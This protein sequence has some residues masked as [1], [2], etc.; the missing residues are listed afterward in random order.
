MSFDKLNF[1]KL[2][3]I[4]ELEEDETNYEIPSESDN[5][6]EAG[7]DINF[8]FDINSI[9]EAVSSLIEEI[10]PVFL[11]IFDIS[12][13]LG[14]V[15]KKLSDT[16]KNKELNFKTKYKMI[17]SISKT[18]VDMLEEKGLIDLEMANEF[19]E[20]FKDSDEY[21]E[22][23]STISNFMSSSK[24]QQQKMVNKALKNMGYKL[25][26]MLE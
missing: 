25:L 15:G 20:V 12:I 16:V 13:F 7:D 9:K 10:N 22:M 8:E 1:D 4:E 6:S 11:S 24:E 3:F 18:V 5:D 14:N 23:I 2:K 17:V 26:Q 19:R 21:N